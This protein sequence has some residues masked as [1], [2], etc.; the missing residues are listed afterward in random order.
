M[1]LSVTGTILQK[2][3]F[4]VQP[5]NLDIT[6]L[7]K[8]VDNFGDIGVVYR[9]ARSLTDLFKGESLPPGCTSLQPTPSSGTTSVFPQRPFSSL[10]LRIIVDNLKSFS[11][12]EP[13]INPDLD[14]QE[15]NGWQIF[16]W[17]A[18]QLC[19]D[20]FSKEP[21]HVILE[22][23]QC[24]RPD[25]LEK[26]LFDV[27]IPNIADI[28]MIDYL[29]AEEYADTFHKLMSLTR[30]ARV[31]KVNFMPGFTAKTGGLIL[32]EPFMKALSK[33]AGKVLEKM[34]DYNG[35][36]YTAK[37]HSSSSFE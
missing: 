1:K 19:F 30:S 8:V 31:K 14:Y 33:G 29:T 27:K 18:E 24:G 37:T 10:S 15:K 32:D 5:N 9:L 34:Q 12:L 3:R 16:Q 4:R 2:K 36:G 11:L 35:D 26:L 28:I 20:T 6:I 21:P 7:C 23:F 17:D 22:C 13:G 25:W